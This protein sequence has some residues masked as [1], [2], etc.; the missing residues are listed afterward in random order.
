MSL[1]VEDKTVVAPGTILAEGMDFLPGGGAF[2]EGDK[3]IASRLGL[4]N[5]DGR[6][7]KLVPLKSSYIPKPGDRIICKVFDISYSGWR[8]NTNTAYPAML[9]I[10]EA[11]SQYIEK[12][13]DLSKIFPIGSYMIAKITNV[14]SQNLIDVSTKGPGL[15]K[16]GAGRIIEVNPA[17]VPRI[18]GKAGS[19]VSM[20]KK[21][22]GCNIM[23]GQNGLVWIRGDN[24]HIAVNAIRKIENEAHT[25]GLT[26]KIEQFLG[27]K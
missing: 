11:S 17:K 19:M 5:V 15:G 23:V 25:Q 10:S 26:E 16:L 12:G 13:A 22:T 21:A 27:G 9:S 24:E 18:I 20:I 1:L 3:V 4:V 8:V 2:R 14:T 7:I 6:A